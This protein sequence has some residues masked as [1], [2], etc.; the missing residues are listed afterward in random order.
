MLTKHAPLT[1]K[2]VRWQRIQIRVALAVTGLSALLALFFL[3]TLE[4][5]EPDTF[6]IKISLPLALGLVAGLSLLLVDQKA[7]AIAPLEP[8]VLAAI[9]RRT[10]NLPAL[11]ALLAKWAASGRCLR[12]RDADYLCGLLPSDKDAMTQK[13]K[14]NDAAAKDELMRFLHEAQ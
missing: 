1:D 10:D 14:K 11:R 12:Q 5:R 4:Y 8:G 2:Q 3:M 6:L 7:H 13:R 9:C